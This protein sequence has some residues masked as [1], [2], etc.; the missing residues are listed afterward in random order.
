MTEGWSTHYV[1]E[2]GRPQC[3]ILGAG[4][5]KRTVCFCRAPL[6]GGTMKAFL[7]ALI[8]FVPAAARA[9]DNP[10]DP[11]IDQKA[12]DAA[13]EKGV[14]FLLKKYSNNRISEPRYHELVLLTLI[15]AGLRADHP[16]IT[17]TFNKM[18]SRNL[19]ETYNVGL[20]AL[21]LE[22]VNRKQYQPSL[23]EIASF[24]A[25]NQ[26]D[27]GQWAYQARG[28]KPLPT[29]YAPVITVARKK[30]LPTGSTQT[31][32]DGPPPGKELRLPPPVRMPKTKSGDNSNSQYA[33]LGLFAASRAAVVVPRETWIDAEKW[34]ESRQNADGGWG[35]ANAEVPGV[36]RVTTDASS[37]S[38]TT[39][40]L[41]A[42][43]VSKF[44]LGKEWKKD[45]SVQKGIEWLGRFFQVNVNPGGPPLWSYYYLY[46]LERVGTISGLAEFGGHRWYKE[47][48]DF[49]IRAQ[50][51]D[52]SWKSPGGAEILTDEVTDTCFAILFLKRA[53][54]PLKKPKD[55]ATGDSKKAEDPA[56]AEK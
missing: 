38:M 22:K 43:I 8:L 21:L 27:N 39:A 19:Q 37:G 36:G 5:Q 32:D 7:A 55:I 2:N 6:N 53:T 33:I 17:E 30:P 41:T 34:F 50:A 49:L 40:A 23:A 44:Y 3:P 54:P 25:E 20:R 51:P 45:A 9:Q 15:H 13:I 16:I 1:H 46:G 31:A 11:D 10:P 24:F 4:R 29:A 56:K 47:G 12:V 26:C 52:G 18:L 42:L 35:Y 28:R 14:G 48:A